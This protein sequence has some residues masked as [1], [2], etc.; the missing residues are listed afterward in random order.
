MHTLLLEYDILVNKQHHLKKKTINNST[1]C[2]TFSATFH[3][4]WLFILFVCFS[5]SPFSIHK[6]A[7]L[8]RIEHH[9]K[10]KVCAALFSFHFQLSFENVLI[11]NLTMTACTHEYSPY[12][13]C[14]RWIILVWALSR[15]RLRNAEENIYFVLYSL[16]FS[17]SFR[18]R[19]FLLLH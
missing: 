5:F 12:N 3:T 16:L 2:H 11:I 13:A 8:S 15:W 10:I 9:T 7:P 17:F 14:K 1:N 19:C 6:Y 18:I 4:V